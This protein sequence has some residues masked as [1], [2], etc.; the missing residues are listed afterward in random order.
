MPEVT[1]PEGYGLLTLKWSFTGKVNPVSTTFGVST[2]GGISE[3]QDIVDEFFDDVS[4]TADLPC[5]ASNMC[6]VWTFESVEGVF[7]VAGTMVGAA[8]AH[9]PISGTHSASAT[10]AMNCS[11]LVRKRS[12]LIG[13]KYRGRMYWP[14]LTMDEGV[15][16]P[17]GNIGESYFDAY[18]ALI[19]GMSEEILLA[20]SYTPVIL[21]SDA[22]PPTNISSL[23]LQKR[24]ATQRRRMRH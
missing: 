6:A 7:N 2:L 15:V 5:H 8:A 21:H 23:S 17:M 9:G 24:I 20:E 12:I 1:I 10:P 3:P 18:N 22:T 19:Q 13:R 14:C 11:M 16:D 4:G